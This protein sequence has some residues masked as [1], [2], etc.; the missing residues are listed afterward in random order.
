MGRRLIIFNS[1]QIGRHAAF[2]F[3]ALCLLWSAPFYFKQ[4][5]DGK[6]PC[7]LFEGT[8]PTMGRHLFIFNSLQTGRHPAYYSKA[9]CP[10]W[11]GI[12]LFLTASRLEG[13][14]LTIRRHSAS[15]WSASFYTAS[16]LEGILPT[17][18]RHSAYYGSASFHFQQPPDGKASCLLFEGT[19]PTMGRRLFIF[20]SIETGRHTAYY[21]EALCLLW[22]CVFSFS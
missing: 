9:L 1:L 17:I 11:V 6:A 18:R 20:N 15:Y 14:L 10:L 5:P 4:P 2:Y 3:K 8:L 13:A 12:C 21:S 19:L 16:R 7:L 22:V